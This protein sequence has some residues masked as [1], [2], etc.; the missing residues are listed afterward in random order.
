MRQANLMIGVIIVAL[1]GAISAGCSS[2][3]SGGGGGAAGAPTIASLSPASGDPA[4]GASVVITGTN[5]DSGTTV[6]LGAV[7]ATVTATTATTI[8]ITTPASTTVGQVDVVVTNSQGSATLT[9]GFSYTSITIASITPSSG[10]PGTPV[11]LTGTGFQ[12]ITSIAPLTTF[13]I[14]S[15]TTITG[16]IA[17][18]TS[19][20][21][22][23]VVV[24]SPIRGNATL[25]PG[26]TYTLG[27]GGVGPNPVSIIG[28]SVLQGDIGGGTALTITG[29]N[30][31]PGNSTVDFGGTLGTISN[32]TTST[33][34]VTTPAHAVGAVT[35][36]VTTNANGSAF[37][38]FF[39]YVDPLGIPN[40]SSIAPGTG[41]ESGGTKV[42]ISGT[43]F[44]N[45]TS[46]RV[47]NSSLLDFLVVSPTSITGKIPLR[48]LATPLAAG[49]VVDGP[50]GASPAFTFTYTKSLILERIVPNQ[51]PVSGTNFVT[52]YG[53]NF[54]GNLDNVKFG[55][56]AAL[57]ITV[58]SDSE[59]VIT[60]PPGTAGPINVTLES[61]LLGSATRSFA[62]TYGDIFQ[63]PVL[64]PDKDIWSTVTQTAAEYA[65]MA[66]I[67]SATGAGLKSRVAVGNFTKSASQQFVAVTI[68]ATNR[69]IVGIQ[70]GGTFTVQT[71]DLAT[72]P[73]DLVWTLTSEDEV[74]DLAVVLNDASATVRL[75]HFTSTA[76]TGGETID[77]VAG[78]AALGVATSIAT[79]D[80]NGDFVFDLATCRGTG[81]V[82]V[83]LSNGTTV[84]QTSVTTIPGAPSPIRIVGAEANGASVLKLDPISD[85]AVLNTLARELLLD[86]NKDGKSDLAVLNL[87]GTVTFLEGDGAFAGPLPAANVKTF[88]ALTPMLGPVDLAVTDL[89]QD[90]R[91]DIAVLTANEV[92]VFRTAATSGGSSVAQIQTLTFP[93]GGV[94]TPTGITFGDFNFD[95]RPDLILSSTEVGGPNISIYLGNGDGSFGLPILYVAQVG[96]NL[97]A[98]ADI[99]DVAPT[100]NRGVWAVSDHPLTAGKGLVNV[101]A[102]LTT[103]YTGDAPTVL[104][105][106]FAS[107]R[108]PRSPRLVDM[109]DDGRTD[110]VF[111]NYADN[112]ITVKLGDGEGGFGVNQSIPTTAGPE[113]LSVGDVN[114]DGRPDVVVAHR[115]GTSL[116]YDE[117]TVHLNL[118]SGTIAPVGTAHSIIGKA[119]R[120]IVLRD[121][122]KDGRLDIVTV[123][124]Q[125][126][127][128]SVLLGTAGPTTWFAAAT[129]FAVQN[130]PL[131]LAL[132]DLGSSEGANA[133]TALAADGNIDIVTAN[134]ADDS[135]TILY[136]NGAG[137]FGSGERYPLD[138]TI[139]ATIPVPGTV[140][141]PSLPRTGVEPSKVAIAD[142]NGDGVLDILTADQGTSTVSILTAN[143]TNVTVSGVVVATN[144]RKFFIPADYRYHTSLADIGQPQVVLPTGMTTQYLRVADMNVDGRLDIIAAAYGGKNL[145]IYLN[146][147][148]DKQG[149]TTGPPWPIY[150]PPAPGAP[151]PFRIDPERH[152]GVGEAYFRSPLTGI[153]PTPGYSV[154]SGVATFY[155]DAVIQ[156]ITGMDVNRINKDC[157]PDVG[158]TLST[159]EVTTHKT[160]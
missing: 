118:G 44:N 23:D 4:G 154:N 111:C 13:T 157:T 153:T 36:T 25:S 160:D 6:T 136:G 84:T 57:N 5:F 78:T 127:N 66:D 53:R 10:A 70:S 139:S 17:A 60:T 80:L 125:T 12:D 159:N 133:T 72:P 101:E 27:G 156:P 97:I 114:Q 113:A 63:N 21:V 155:T 140:G 52:I 124:Q 49:V 73:V 11:T 45:A 143:A 75:I 41:P 67:S 150:T 87:N 88:G 20:S 117:V 102:A 122:N 110:L 106:P 33:I 99:L 7:N 61:T 47:G 62:Y 105:P 28:I 115:L 100:R 15:L 38:S 149:G 158:L 145:T 2:G 1:V 18:G 141:L 82:E 14:Q 79:A 34:L 22:V 9:G 90:N 24:T 29:V 104:T 109:N 107:G 93:T 98:T 132:A 138:G 83:F 121:V 94:T 92:A 144:N 32:V 112:T 55:I 26:F 147:G 68:P 8:T 74:P 43:N 123:N 91:L 40:I 71:Y 64:V 42:T 148:S 65:S 128:V 16:T 142:I 39:N 81:S 76:P 31:Q 152:A 56:T 3:S 37:Y 96:P 120:E 35:V 130:E 116:P 30:F 137:S 86:L 46:A 108:E 48:Q 89:D 126:N 151:A 77:T 85:V 146:G 58:I 119:P 51:G 135:V 50:N 131:G 134:S 59:A 103:I 54:N 69:V 129:V 95:C 19:G